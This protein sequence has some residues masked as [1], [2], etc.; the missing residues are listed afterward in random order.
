MNI[1]LDMARCEV[2]SKVSPVGNEF[3]GRDPSPE[4]SEC[5]VIVLSKKQSLEL[6]TAA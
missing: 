5:K 2:S 4:F 1:K 6:N 3:S